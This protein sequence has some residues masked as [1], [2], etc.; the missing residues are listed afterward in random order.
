M[1]RQRQPKKKP[2]AR[3]VR[4]RRTDHKSEIE[5]RLDR[6]LVQQEVR[7]E[8]ERLQVPQLLEAMQEYGTFVYNA[9]VILNDMRS[10]T[11]IASS[12]LGAASSTMGSVFREYMETME[13]ALGTLD[14]YLNGPRLKQILEEAAFEAEDVFASSL[15]PLP[16]PGYAEEEDIA[17]MVATD[18]GTAGA[19]VSYDNDEDEYVPPQNPIQSGVRRITPRMARGTRGR[20]SRGRT[21]T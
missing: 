20:T 18:D 10:A 8:I 5:S 6:S 9:A 7:A 19:Y 12:S 16:L 15:P 2:G 4:V 21:R 13:M 1:V 11:H 14:T 17:R 3:R